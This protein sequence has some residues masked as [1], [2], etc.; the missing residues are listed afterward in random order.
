MTTLLYFNIFTNIPP[1]IDCSHQSR[2]PSLHPAAL[3]SAAGKR[4][5]RR[6]ASP[7]G[8]SSYKPG[9]GALGRLASESRQGWVVPNFWL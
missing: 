9:A 6:N 8:I 7:P 5:S 4:K 3:K 2:A 1:T